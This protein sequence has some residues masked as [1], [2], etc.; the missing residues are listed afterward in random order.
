MIQGVEPDRGRG[1]VAAERQAFWLR[2]QLNLNLELG[3]T[4]KFVCT[5]RMRCRLP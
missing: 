2:H 4:T 3:A 5:T 1:S